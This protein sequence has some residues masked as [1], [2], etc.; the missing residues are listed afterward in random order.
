M[1]VSSDRIALERE[2]Q[3]RFQSA[4]IDQPCYVLQ[5]RDLGVRG[6]MQPIDELL[7]QLCHLIDFARQH[8]WRCDLSRH[9]LT[10]S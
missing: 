8:S 3:S 2:N 10:S 5:E 6:C 1:R 4:L 7:V 9:I